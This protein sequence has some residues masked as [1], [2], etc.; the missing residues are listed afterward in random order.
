M[1]EWTYYEDAVCDDEIRPGFYH[2]CYKDS[3]SKENKSE[4]VEEALMNVLSHVDVN[5]GPLWQW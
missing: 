2:T 3:G 1:T 4:E 5:E